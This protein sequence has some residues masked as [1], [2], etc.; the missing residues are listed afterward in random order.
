MDD[1]EIGTE[2]PCPETMGT[3][4]RDCRLALKEAV[5]AEDSLAVQSMMISAGQSMTILQEIQSQCNL[6]K[7]CIQSCRADE[8]IVATRDKAS[9]KRSHPHD[10]QQDDVLCDNESMVLQC[11]DYHGECSGPQC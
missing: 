8:A 3:R 9:L 4:G 10:C 7:A 5:P 1:D 2:L 6:H 11:V